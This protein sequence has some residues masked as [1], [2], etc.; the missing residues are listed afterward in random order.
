MRSSF[1]R[2]SRRLPSPSVPREHTN[3]FEEIDSL[4]ER[5][6]ELKTET[7]DLVSRFKKEWRAAQSKI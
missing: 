6:E 3:A 2:F 4:Y 7:S 5:C 1:N